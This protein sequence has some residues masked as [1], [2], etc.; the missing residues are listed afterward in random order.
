MLTHYC[1]IVFALAHRRVS[2][3][4]FLLSRLLTSNLDIAC[5]PPTLPILYETLARNKLCP[6]TIKKAWLLGC[7]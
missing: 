5:R 1:D 2:L 7:C 4:I 3:P 6:R